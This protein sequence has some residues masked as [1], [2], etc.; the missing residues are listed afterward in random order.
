[1]T[2]IHIANSWHW[3][4]ADL[5]DYGISRPELNVVAAVERTSHRGVADSFW[6][7][8]AELDVVRK[9]EGPEG[10]GVGADGSEKHAGDAWVH[11][12][13]FHACHMLIHHMLYHS[14]A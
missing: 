1:M 3:V 5:H 8:D 11:L 13:A 4:F 7:L 12:H 6:D 14:Y 9:D 10:E 2:R